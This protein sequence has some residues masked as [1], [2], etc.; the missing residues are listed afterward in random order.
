[1]GFG[2]NLGA[3]GRGNGFC[4]GVGFDAFF[5]IRGKHGMCHGTGVLT[6]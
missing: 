5:L 2:K 1:M 3:N 6:V 4:W